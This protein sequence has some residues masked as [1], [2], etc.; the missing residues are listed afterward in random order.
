MLCTVTPSAPVE[1]LDHSLKTTVLQ[2]YLGQ[3]AHVDFAKFFV[4]KARILEVMKLCAPPWCTQ[5]WLEDQC[6]RLN[7]ENI[8]SRFAQFHFVLHNDLP[9]R[10]WMDGAFS[11]NDPFIECL[12]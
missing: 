12:D 5:V 7:I 2:S 11:R 4:T 6:R 8:A 3:K 9:L 10:F 1:C